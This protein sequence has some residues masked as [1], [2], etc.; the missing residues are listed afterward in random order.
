MF[1]I[2]IKMIQSI[3]HSYE[4]RKHNINRLGLG[5]FVLFFVYLRR[6]NYVT[7][8]DFKFIKKR[9]YHFHQIS[10]YLSFKKKKS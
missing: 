2:C 3:E 7:R 10:I 8:I 9:L 6:L 4:K 5:V 1:K